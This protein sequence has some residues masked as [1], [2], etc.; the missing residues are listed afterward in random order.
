MQIL[1]STGT[2]FAFLL[3]SFPTFKYY[4]SALVIAGLAVLALLLVLPAPET[5][6]WLL[7]HGQRSRAIR[8]LKLLRG[9]SC[10]INREL[11]EIENDIAMTS[12]SDQKF[13]KSLKMLISKAVLA[14]LAIII[15]TQFFQQLGGILAATSYSSSIYKLAGVKDYRLVSTCG[16]GGTQ[17]LVTIVVIF[18]IDIFG[19]K[20]LLIASGLGVFT[21]TLMLGIH[22]YI[23]R[24]SL[25]AHTLNNTITIA[26]S[27]ISEILS[28]EAPV[29][30]CNKQ[31]A[32]LAIVSL[33]LFFSSFTIGWGPVPGILLGELLPLR[34]R[35][36]ASG[37][38]SFLNWSFAVVVTGT[39]LDFTTLLEPWV[40]WWGY[41]FI[42]L[43]SVVFVV[44]FVFE[45]KGKSLE[46]IE[47][48]FRRK[49][50]LQ[51]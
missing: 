30:D 3:G 49:K 9:K 5:P 18:L 21:A 51:C 1:L 42:N 19:R 20:V 39:Y 10:D 15:C 38:A 16:N 23:T 29:I 2:M 13:T 41:S 44:V 36:I 6:R 8:T 17:I 28:T 12:C 46:Q 35:G 45:T 34:V 25:C 37:I 50:C 33:I 40:V 14:P 31:F 27:G 32:P 43:A 22:F 11:S 7:V 47:E 4:D 26:Q 48:R 24:P